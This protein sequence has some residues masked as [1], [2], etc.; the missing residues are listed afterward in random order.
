[1]KALTNSG[2]GTAVGHTQHKANTT[3]MCQSKQ[4]TS[5]HCI[6]LLVDSGQIFLQ[7]L[8][9]PLDTFKILNW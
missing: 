7:Y 2:E 6:P 8:L 1:M 9:V 5:L 3:G 4:G